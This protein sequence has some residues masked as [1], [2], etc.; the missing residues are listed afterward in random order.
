VN[1]KDWPTL[2]SVVTFRDAV[3]RRLEALYHDLATGKRALTRN[4]A[5]TLVMTHE[6]EGFHIEVSVFRF[7][8]GYRPYL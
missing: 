4:I 8:Q 7:L 5:R 2:D 3:R 6:H 1:D